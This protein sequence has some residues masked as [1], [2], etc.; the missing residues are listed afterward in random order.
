MKKIFISAVYVLIFLTSCASTPETHFRNARQ[1]KEENKVD[2]A[3]AEYK[4]A[5]KLKPKFHEAAV[6]LSL[7]YIEKEEFVKAWKVISN[8]KGID[9]ERKI[10]AAMNKKTIEIDSKTSLENHKGFGA[11]SRHIIDTVIRR[12]I[13]EIASCYR[14]ELT[15][16]PDIKGKVVVKFTITPEGMVVDQN[17]SRTSLNNKNVEQCS[18]EAVG[19]IIFPRPKFGGKVI[20]NYPFVFKRS[21]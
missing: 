18:A 11:L 3:I 19:R 5:L 15:N 16:N 7:L 6:N 4:M 17:V 20:V 21:E 13:E 14:K 9:V 1:Y 8:V 2:E 10:I 12:H